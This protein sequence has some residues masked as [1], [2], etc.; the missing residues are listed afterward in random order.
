MA[1]TLFDLPT[2]PEE[3]GVLLP[4]SELRR[5]D[6]SGLDY[7]TARRAI[8]EYIK[9]Y[10]PDQFNDFIAS[11]GIMMITEVVSAVV[12][13]LALRSDML[14][15]NA[16]IG[17]SKSER[18]IINHLALINQRIKRQ[19]PAV[20]DIEL[21]IDQPVS[22]DIEID[23]GLLFSA[24]GPDQQNIIYEV[25]RSP[26]DWTSK[27]IIPAGKRGVIAWGV[28]GQFASQVII[29]SAGGPNQRFIISEP[30]MLESPIFV[31]VTVG[32]DTEEWTVITEPIERYNPNDK[33]VEVNF[34]EDSAVFQFGN[35]VNGQSP[36]SGSAITF[37]YRVGGG[38]RGRIGVGQINSSRPIN[39]LPPANAAV[40][41][42][43]IN[44]SP[45]NG[46]TD[47]ESV[48]NAKRR[49]PRDYATQRSI[50]TAEDYAQVAANFSHPV[51]GSVAKAIATIRTGLNAN[52]VEIY[53]LV[54][55]PDSIPMIPNAGLKAGLQ[56][57]FSDLNVLTDHVVI[58]DGALKPVDI[59]VNII[60][61][62]SADASVVKNRVEAAITNFFNINNWELGEPFYLSNFIEVI[63]N[64]DGVAYVD[65][66]SPSDNILPSG[67]LGNDDRYVIGFNQLIIEGT[68]KTNYFYE[69][70]NY[71]AGTKR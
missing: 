43:F 20:T 45:S 54:E 2:S 62:K 15:N 12:A 67:E 34:F 36:L 33:V 41:V 6:F 25:Y 60:I 10:W 13:K 16:F 23:P 69:N 38:I 52:R 30:N 17:T 29:T 19:T 39:P 32:N 46:G 64:I 18:A 53:C 61:S 48:E 68:R 11:N 57:Y 9:T 14:A 58:L 47:K 70:A 56:T 51:F 55:G 66:F 24:R 22:T 35:D 50:V 63:E 27:I 44:I 49:A 40:T 4:P 1:E 65:F 5:F 8:I 21:S 59:D 31:T 37:R 7:D 3:F 42:S 28:E 26:N 71:T